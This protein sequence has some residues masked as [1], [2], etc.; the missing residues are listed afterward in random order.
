MFLVTVS[1]DTYYQGDS[2]KLYFNR[3]FEIHIIKW[4]KPERNL[5]QLETT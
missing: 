5:M 3:I 1:I 4:E 2:F